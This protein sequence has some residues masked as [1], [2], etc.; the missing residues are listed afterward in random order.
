MRDPVV[1]ERQTVAHWYA[2]Y[3]RPRFEKKIDL[4]LREK[5]LESYLPLHTVRRR[6]SD[7]WKK[8]EQPLFSC[9]VFVKIAL[10]D[11]I[12]VVQTHGVV[13]MVSF[14]GT[15]SPI[16]DVEINA[17]KN[18]LEHADSFETTHYLAIG[19]MVEVIRGSLEGIR[20]R[21]VEHRGQKRLLV[22]IEQIR[23]AITIEVNEFDVQPVAQQDVDARTASIKYR[24]TGMME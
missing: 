8:V 17:V 19:Q 7:R 22:A 10:R 24:N 14:N 12:Y 15:P 23:Q 9:Y 6:W 20:G 5:G 13:R 11:K 18:V 3:T 4:K 1:E 16:P 21:L 2:L